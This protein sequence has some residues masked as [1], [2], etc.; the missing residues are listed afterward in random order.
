MKT[1][2]LASEALL[3]AL[4]ESIKARSSNGIAMDAWDTVFSEGGALLSA[5]I[6]FQHSTPFTGLKL[7][8][9]EQVQLVYETYRS[10]LHIMSCLPPIQAYRLAILSDQ[11]FPDGQAQHALRPVVSQALA[12]LISREFTV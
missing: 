5:L 1:E 3:L 6:P 2:D 9:R 4:E 10:R 11:V 7:P 8:S 12:R